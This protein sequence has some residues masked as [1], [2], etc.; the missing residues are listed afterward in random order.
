MKF[1]CKNCNFHWEGWIDT[2]SKVL[3]HEKTHLKNNT[4][5]SEENN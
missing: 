5:H 4:V 2:F 3:D 1:H